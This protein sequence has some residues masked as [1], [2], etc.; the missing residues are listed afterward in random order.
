MNASLQWSRN[1]LEDFKKQIAYIAEHNPQAAA[2]VA[3]RIDD[4]ARK[5]SLRSTG[6]PGRVDGTLEKTVTGL[7]YIVAYAVSTDATHTVITILRLIHTAR[8]WRREKWP[9]SS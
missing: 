7:P 5:L 6:R 4:C 1:A 8:D 2:K 9:P 3:E